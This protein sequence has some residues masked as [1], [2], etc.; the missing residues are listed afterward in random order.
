MLSQRFCKRQSFLVMIFEGRRKKQRRMLSKPLTS[1][2]HLNMIL[3]RL[4]YTK[5]SM[6]LKTMLIMQRKQTDKQQWL[7]AFLTPAAPTF[8]H[9]KLGYKGSSTCYFQKMQSE[10][11]LSNEWHRYRNFRILVSRHFADYME[12]PQVILFTSINIWIRVANA[13]MRQINSKH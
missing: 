12:C 7:L 5:Q 10:L 13:L 1:R 11:A 8:T 4:V 3:S 6:A 2:D 9:W